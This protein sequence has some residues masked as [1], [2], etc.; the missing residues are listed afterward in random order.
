MCGWML[1]S[2]WCCRPVVPDGSRP[3]GQPMSRA[4]A[5]R[6]GMQPQTRVESW[7]LYHSSCPCCI[8]TQDVF[9]MSN[10]HCPMSIC[11]MLGRRHMHIMPGPVF[12][13]LPSLPFDSVRGAAA[14][15]FRR[16]SWQLGTEEGERAKGE[17][18]YDDDLNVGQPPPWAVLRLTW[19]FSQ[20][21]RDCFRYCVSSAIGHSA[22]VSCESIPPGLLSQS[23]PSPARHIRL[24]G[25]A[26]YPAM[27]PRPS[28]A[29]AP[30]VSRRF[31]ASH[32]PLARGG[33]GIGKASAWPTITSAHCT[34]RP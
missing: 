23:S 21:T 27:T 22:L 11:H 26:S 7:S 18:S 30:V 15:E 34:V 28:L 24:R 13:V 4:V 5:S 14:A 33:R 8:L 17:G 10:V 31:V 32:A 19:S 2:W 12:V 9:Q 1:G 29:S 20:L 6:G 25:R 16:G 3:L